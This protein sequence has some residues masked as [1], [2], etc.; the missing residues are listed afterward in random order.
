V[1]HENTGLP[2]MLQTTSSL[3]TLYLYD[4]I[5]NPTALSTSASTT[6]YN[7]RFDPYGAETR[8][9]T[10]GNNGGWVDNPYVFQGGVQDRATGTIK[11]GARW[12]NPTTGGWTQQDNLNTPL[13]PGNADRY[14]YAAGNPINN[15]DPSGLF[16][17]DSFAKSLILSV[18]IAVVCVPV[19]VFL[20]PVAGV[21]CGI[22]GGLTE[23]A[24][25]GANG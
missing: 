8:L 24:V 15:N 10:G 1:M 2:V 3:T 16:S 25:A 23:A 4:G 9:D 21:A 18:G 6:S 13:D 19:G 22:A 12:F 11:F 20:S 17:F 5:G 7:L 14:Q